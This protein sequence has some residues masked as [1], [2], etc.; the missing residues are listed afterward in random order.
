MFTTNASFGLSAA[1]ADEP[2][3]TASAT[4]IAR[5]VAKIRFMNS[6]QLPCSLPSRPA[7]A[8]AALHLSCKFYPW[9]ELVIQNGFLSVKSCHRRQFQGVGVPGPVANGE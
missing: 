1:Y 6:S 8:Q 5:L 7:Q 4:L 9:Q 2:A 3:D